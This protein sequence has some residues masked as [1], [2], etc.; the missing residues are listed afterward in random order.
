MDKANVLLIVDVQKAFE[1]KK[2]G[3]RNNLN[4][5]NNIKR[6]LDLWRTKGWEVIHIHHE[7]HDPDSVFYVDGEGF[8]P[9]RE[10]EPLPHEKRFTK[11]VNSAFIGTGLNE[12]LMEIQAKRLV[13]TG[14]TTPH[15]VST[16]TR[17]SGNLGYETVLL[18]DA[19]AAFG[20]YDHHGDYVEPE[21]I[22]EVSLATL[23]DE[24]ASVISTDSLIHSVARA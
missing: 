20:L 7:S 8:Q 21:T 4:A 6:V 23:H 18:S 5:E 12:Y 9:K 15:C 24:F 19:T 10:M 22:H 13:I 3:K 17:M 16:T 11:K 2:W 14:L 1:H